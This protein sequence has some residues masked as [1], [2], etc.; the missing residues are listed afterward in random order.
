[1][2]VFTMLDDTPMFRKRL[3]QL[4]EGTEML[5]DR[6]QRLVKGSKKYADG[7][8]DGCA[9]D[10]AFARAIEQFGTAGGPDDPISVAVGGPVMSKFVDA[11]KELRSYKEVLKTQVEH[12]LVDRI[13][14][15][16]DFELH[17]L[18]DV[19]R[20][21]EKASHHYDSARERCL[22]LKKDAKP[23]VMFDA[24]AELQIAK[25]NYEQARFVFASAVCSIEGKKKYE[26]VESVACTLDAHLR[27]F[28]QGYELLRGLEPFVQQVLTFS[29]Q[30][31]EAAQQEQAT[32]LNQVSLLAP[33]QRL[34]LISFLCICLDR[35]TERWRG[36][37][38]TSQ[39]RETHKAV[40]YLSFLLAL[41]LELCPTY[42]Q[43]MSCLP[44]A[45]AG[46]GLPAGAAT[47]TGGRSR[48]PSRG[49]C[50]R[51][52]AVPACWGVVTE[53]H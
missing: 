19:R 53:S 13:S 41:P 3:Q 35:S 30:A 26:Y 9:A 34:H 14:K 21:L 48:G 24:E 22:S 16:R 43:F 12:M 28:K 6:S 25:M 20:K 39:I 32:F 46:G 38:R 29:Q 36:S 8:S 37:Y 42:V 44:P 5:R 17:N 10:L 40:G 11:L 49:H 2:P 15:F 47:G 45:C 51:A 50:R 31:R 27:Y 7:L 1:M 52:G 18:R 23:E 4:E 33:L